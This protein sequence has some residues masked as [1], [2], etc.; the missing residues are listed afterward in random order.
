MADVLT[1]RCY[2]K[3]KKEAPSKVP[4]IPEPEVL[5]GAHRLYFDGAYKRTKD[6]ASAGIVI[7]GPEKEKIFAKGFHLKE[8]YSNNEAEYHALVLGLQCCLSQG[9]TKLNVF[10]DSMLIVKKMVGVW[11]CKNDKLS[12]KMREAKALLKGFKEVRVHFVPRDQN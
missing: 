4:P 12:V 9:I 3:A 11:A 5:L 10:G 1:Q 8:V 2:E 6:K 7:L